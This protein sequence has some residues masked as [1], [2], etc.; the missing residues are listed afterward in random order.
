MVA[1]LFIE[2]DYITIRLAFLAV[3]L[4]Y[5]LMKL[6]GIFKDLEHLYY[7]KTIIYIAINIPYKFSEDILINE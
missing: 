6:A 1:I 3:Y 4:S 7:F 5:K 2:L